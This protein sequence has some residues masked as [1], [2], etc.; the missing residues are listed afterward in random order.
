MSE[1]I[2]WFDFIERAMTSKR[3]RKKYLLRPRQKSEVSWVPAC[4]SDILAENTKSTLKI[5]PGLI[6]C[7][8]LEQQFPKG[9]TKRKRGIIRGMSKGARRR[10]TQL[11]LGRISTRPRFWQ[12]LTFPDD[13]M[14]GLDLPGRVRVAKKAFKRWHERLTYRYPG[15][16]GIFRM[17]C[18]IRKSGLLQGEKVPHFHVV[19][20]LPGVDQSLWRDELGAKFGAWW[21]KALKS[22]DYAALRVAV[23]QR[24]YRVIENKAHCAYY[25]SKY[26]AKEDS[27]SYEGC[28]RH[29]GKFGHV[30]ICAPEPSELGEYEDVAMRRLARHILPKNCF[31]YRLAQR[32][33]S[34]SLYLSKVT[35]DRYISWWLGEWF[36]KVGDDV[37]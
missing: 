7:R 33:G 30:P 3:D 14:E 21:F 11:I 31:S 25:V 17:E 13:V 36:G 22:F 16:W 34:F 10:L 12:D 24:S 19:Y 37:T 9:S 28:G 5:F 4:N 2:E 26:I 27:D 20:E 1:E 35:Y 8:S 32:G 15:S 23:D 6:K 18:Q 29:W